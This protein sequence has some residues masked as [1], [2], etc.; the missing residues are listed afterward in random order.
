MLGQRQG[1]VAQAERQVERVRRGP[2]AAD[3]VVVV[4]SPLVASAVITAS[5]S[6][7]TITPTKTPIQA[8]R[9]TPV[10]CRKRYPLP[11]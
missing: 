5:P 4:P 10:A 2:V 6:P 8:P 9:L 11:R 3:V 7:R 1:V